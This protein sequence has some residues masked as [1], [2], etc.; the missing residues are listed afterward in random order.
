M[1]QWSIEF[2]GGT[3]VQ[4]KFDKPIHNEIGK[5]RAIVE[6]LSATPVPR[7]K[8][9]GRVEDDRNGYRRVRKQGDAAVVGKQIP[10]ALAQAMPRQ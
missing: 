10:D 1:V 9:I 4:L 2:V 3:L 5:V 7:I 6:Q 8:M